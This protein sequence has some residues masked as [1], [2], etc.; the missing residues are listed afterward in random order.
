MIPDSH[1][2]PPMF[3]NRWSVNRS[4]PPQP[5]G[6]TSGQLS[7]RSKTGRTPFAVTSIDVRRVVTGQA[8][9]F[10]LLTTWTAGRFVGCASTRGAPANKKK[11]LASTNENR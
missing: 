10:G 9:V 2:V 1:H 3:R 6:V 5:G 11:T 4:G 7:Q 8:N